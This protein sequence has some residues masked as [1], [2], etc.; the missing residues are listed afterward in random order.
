MNMNV[1]KSTKY[2]LKLNDLTQY[3]LADALEI[4][5]PRVANICRSRHAG[6]ALVERLAKAFG[7]SVIEFIEVG[8]E[9]ELEE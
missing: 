3:E 1:G 4:S 9:E 7:V 5:Q 8:L 6:T 2:Y